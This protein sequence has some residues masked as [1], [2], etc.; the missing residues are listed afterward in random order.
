MSKELL[1]AHQ[2]RT[3]SAPGAYRDGG[4]LR[5]IVTVRGVKRWEVWISINGK[6]KERGLGVYPQVSLKDARDKA[7]D[8]KRA[9]RD[10]IDLRRQKVNGQAHAVTFRQAFEVCFELRRKQL[11]NAKH[12]KQWS[13]TMTTYVFPLLGD[14]PVAEV[15]T[16]QVL[17]VLEP[18]WYSKSET[19][20]RVLQRMEVVFKS[21]I[22]RGMRK[23]ASPC[24]GVAQELGTRHRDVKHHPSLSWD[25]VPAFLA[26]LRNAGQRGWP[27]TRLAFEFLI[28]TAT[29]SGETRVAV[30]AEFDF[31]KALWIIPKERMKSRNDHC[32]PLSGRCLAILQQARAL[33]PD[34]DLVFEGTKKGR[35]L[36]DMTFTKLLRDA[37]LG[38]R[39]TA[40][41]FRSSFKTWCAVVAKTPDDVSEAALAHT[42]RDEIKAAYLRTDFLAE[43]T[44]L[45]EAWATHCRSGHLSSEPHTLVAYQA[46]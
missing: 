5:L 8:I 26:T 22:V 40:H 11:S 20:K 28:L 38:E 3:V 12:L 33:N 41:G 6:R 14:V 1:T 19:A 25:E 15:T 9:A 27:A 10:G 24:V 30:W 34:G 7:H 23:L 32:V 37:G 29:R 21:A 46:A 31:E 2:V 18:I 16:S 43:R 42:M 39:A 44:P 17:A 45:M 13:S 36:S 35:P 4:G